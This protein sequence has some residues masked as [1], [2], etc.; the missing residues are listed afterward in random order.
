[1]SGMLKLPVCPYCG[2]RF[3]YP[4]VKKAASQKTGT[5]THCNKMF[6][7][8]RK[9]QYLL[10]FIAFFL[11]VA[12]NWIFLTAPAVNLVFLIAVTA[13]GVVAAWALVP[14][15]VRY[16]KEKAPKNKNNKAS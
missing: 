7:I 5:C 16:R 10:F 3:L 9:Y 13:P 2:A 11:L 14:F 6:Q 15:T 1:M 8:D 12:V 4:E